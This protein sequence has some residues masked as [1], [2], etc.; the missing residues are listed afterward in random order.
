MKTNDFEK[1]LR[2]SA[3]RFWLEPNPA[4]F[5]RVMESLNKEKK[6]RRLIFAIFFS[7]LGIGLTAG[8]T[9]IIA[10]HLQRNNPV[11]F[12]NQTNTDIHSDNS[13]STQS[14]N[15]S[16]IES[17]LL[18]LVHNP[19]DNSSNA[20]APMTNNKYS[21]TQLQNISGKNKNSLLSSIS[22]KNNEQQNN[23]L[24]KEEDEKLA[25]TFT[26]ENDEQ[27]NQRNPLY[28]SKNEMQLLYIQ[29]FNTELL[30][31]NE[32]AYNIKE[33]SKLQT[34]LNDTPIV[35]S[36]TK[37]F[38]PYRNKKWFISG[39][40]YGYAAGNRFAENTDH[41][42]PLLAEASQAYTK[43]RNYYDTYR[44]GFSAG[45]SI[46]FT[47]IKYLSIEIGVQYTEFTALE[48]PLG[49]PEQLSDS[50]APQ[51]PFPF[52]I[53][54]NN[55][56][57]I[58]SSNFKLIQFPLLFTF[59]WNW[60]NSGIHVSAGPTFSYTNS[61]VG[62][63]LMDGKNGIINQTEIDSSRIQRFGISLQTKLLYS[64][65]ILPNF[66]LYAGPTF[67]YRFTSIFDNDY[68]IRQNPFFIGLETGLRFHF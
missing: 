51:D 7:L 18:N 31:N 64:Q 12:N 8:L 20:K 38:D 57:K 28:A 39:L 65:Q 25:A 48:K 68:F 50:L 24:I 26:N 56:G 40:F 19:V 46:G 17:P 2:E 44:F 49:Y 60:K 13:F 27:R 10:E 58:F 15:D 54:K 67:Q 14:K 52:Y 42:D 11:V 5:G 59:N 4:T 63:E 30:A 62:Y 66:S 32:H 21:K 3:D 6:R 29:T 23:V 45:G 61:F 16:S 35:K 53:S 33:K 47:P 37:F 36:K 43:F 34:L 41:T 55:Q 9:W 1:Y 22:T